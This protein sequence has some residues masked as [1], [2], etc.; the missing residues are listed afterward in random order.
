[1]NIIVRTIRDQ[2]YKNP[3]LMHKFRGKRME[4]MLELLR[5]PAGAR[6]IDLGGSEYN[7]GLI[8][9]DFH[10]TMVNLPGFNPPVS[11]PSRFEAVEGD[12]C[13]LRGRY[14]D[15]SFDA[16]FS[17]SVIEHVG[18]EGQQ[19]KFATEARRLAPAYWVQTPSPR[20]PIEIH[21]GVPLY[22][23]LP[24]SIREGLLTRW[25]RKWPGWVD[26]I[27]ETRVLSE[28]RLRELFPDG[29]LYCERQFGLEKS[30]TI[31]RPA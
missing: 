23:K 22:W 14:A 7:W 26:M 15:N 2:A 1:M 16:V 12:A 3:Y 18:D 20:F 13:D 29:R 30:N 8:K 31:Y 5:L 27:R 9:H 4:A 21:T 10:V 17:N 19:A 28:A 11:D 24:A 6:I 25:N